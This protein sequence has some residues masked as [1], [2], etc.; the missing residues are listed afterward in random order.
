MDTVND[1]R[2]LVAED[3]LN[4]LENRV[5]VWGLPYPL[6]R[7]LAT[8]RLRRLRSALMTLKYSYLP[9]DLLL[10]SEALKEIES[11]TKELIPTLLPPKEVR[12][13][14]V[15]HK[16]A[17]AEIKYAISTLLGLKSRLALGEEGKP[18]EAVDVLGVEVVSVEKHP[19]ADNLWVVKAGTEKFSFTIVT[20]IPNVKKGEVR[21]VAILPPMNFLGVVSEGS[22]LRKL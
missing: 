22:H 20:N 16:L 1:Y 10:Q 18:E 4:R 9:T 13:E 7:S 8:E 3:A 21:A 14:S 17:V 15:A 12:L 11:L 5:K 2:V 6:N 19:N